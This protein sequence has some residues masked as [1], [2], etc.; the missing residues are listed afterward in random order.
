MALR[1]LYVTQNFYYPR[2]MKRY[3]RK[4]FKLEKPEY[5]Y[6]KEWYTTLIFFRERMENKLWHIQ[7]CK[8]LNNTK[9]K[10]L[11]NPT[12]Q[13]ISVCANWKKPCERDYLLYDFIKS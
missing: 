4:K 7:L 11:I 2:E 9:N 13:K 5:F 6:L 1:Q 8:G 10:L 12:T 3:V